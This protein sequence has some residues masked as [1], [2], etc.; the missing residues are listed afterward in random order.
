MNKGNMLFVILLLGP[1]VGTA[2]A[3][4][5]GT[6]RFAR[7]FLSEASRSSTPA[8]P[9]RTPPDSWNRRGH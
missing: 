4:P 7:V 5:A 3:E 1:L 9:I 6:A 8:G 2:A